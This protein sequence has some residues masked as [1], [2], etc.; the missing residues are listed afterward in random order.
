MN[1]TIPLASLPPI[2]GGKLSWTLNAYYNSKVWDVTRSQDIG[3]AFDLSQHYYTVDSVVASDRGGWR[4]TGQYAIEIRNAHSDFDYELPPVG[5][6]DYALMVNYQWYKV[7]LV[8]PD[9]SEHELRPVDYSPFP[10]AAEFLRGYYSQSPY[11]IG[12]MRYYSFD[13]SYL[14][15]TVTTETNWTVYLPDGTRVIQTADGVQRIQDTNGNRIKIFSDADGTHYQD[16]LTLR[17]IR[18]KFDPTANNGN[19]QGRVSY[20]TVGGGDWLYIDINF[21]T[22]NVVGKLYNV[23]GWKPGQVNE[24]PC[25]YQVQLNGLLQTVDEIVLPSAEP[26][27][28]GRRFTFDYNSEL[29]ESATNNVRLGSCVA[30]F[31]AYTRQAAKGWGSLSRMVT[32]AGAEIL[33]SYKMDSPAFQSH[34]VFTPDDIPAETI[35]KKTIVQDGPD[36][37]WTYDIWPDLGAASQTYVNDNS[38]VSENAYPQN[39]QL[40]TGFGGGYYGVSGL[41]Y[42]TTSPFQK[43]E[44]H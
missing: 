19:G 14:S 13:G 26:G 15:A 41:T 23:N 4:I 11:A 27:Q 24:Q 25:T 39:A 9:G 42:R 21:G 18:Y 37:V 36:D 31:Q 33:Y 1:L 28:P 20:K 32:P 38:V 6:G 7:V 35:T 22:T 5:D 12:T 17:E 29:T 34:F 8:M 43:V 44:R 10:G 30:P 2:A 40:G 3:T 16:E